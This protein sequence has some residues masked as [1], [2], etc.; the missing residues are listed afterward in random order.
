MEIQALI[1]SPLTSPFKGAIAPFVYCLIHILY[2]FSHLHRWPLHCFKIFG[3]QFDS[4]CLGIGS[5]IVSP[6]LSSKF[7]Y[8]HQPQSRSLCFAPLSFEPHSTSSHHNSAPLF[9]IVMQIDPLNFLVLRTV[10]HAVELSIFPCLQHTC[11]CQ[12]LSWQ[13]YFSVKSNHVCIHSKRFNSVW[14]EWRALKPKYGLVR[15]RSMAFVTSITHV[16][17]TRSLL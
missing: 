3:S 16:T 1:Y 2:A 17:Q 14:A 4:H 12:H 8:H 6:T 11:V 5:G 9:R 13:K 7:V 15:R 10:C